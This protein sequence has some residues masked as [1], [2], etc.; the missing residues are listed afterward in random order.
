MLFEETVEVKDLVTDV[1]S[2]PGLG[3]KQ[4]EVKPVDPRHQARTECA[5]TQHQKTAHNSILQVKDN[6]EYY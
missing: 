6:M 2:L 4:P 1:N 5:A 3:H